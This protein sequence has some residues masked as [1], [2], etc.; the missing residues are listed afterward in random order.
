MLRSALRTEFLY[1]NKLDLQRTRAYE[2]YV[3]PQVELDTKPPPSEE[4][5]SQKQTDADHFPAD[6]Y[7]GLT[8]ANSI[9]GGAN[10]IRYGRN[11]GSQHGSA[12]HIAHNLHAKHSRD[13]CR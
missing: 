7:S 11:R 13:L 3:V 9:R 2:T 1:Q 4:N 6:W 5:E 10:M 12:T 8:V